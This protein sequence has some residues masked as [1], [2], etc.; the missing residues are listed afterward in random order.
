MGQFVEGRKNEEK[1][2]E[3]EKRPHGIELE[4][5]EEKKQVREGIVVLEECTKEEMIENHKTVLQ[6]QHLQDRLKNR[7]E[8]KVGTAQALNQMDRPKSIVLDGQPNDNS[9]L[10]LP[11]NQEQQVSRTSDQGGVQTAMNVI[12][13][14]EKDREERLSRNRKP[15]NRP[16]ARIEMP[17]L[18]NTSRLTLTISQLIESRLSEGFEAIK[19]QEFVGRDPDK[20]KGHLEKPKRLQLQLA[21]R[22]VNLLEERNSGLRFGSTRLRF[23]E[24]LLSTPKAWQRKKARIGFHLSLCDQMNQSS[25]YEEG[26]KKYPVY[27]HNLEI[28]GMN[29]TNVTNLRGLKQTANL[30]LLKQIS[31]PSE[32]FRAVRNR[33]S[34]TTTNAA[35][36]DGAKVQGS[37]LVVA[38]DQEALIGRE[39]SA[40]GL[41]IGKRTA[42]HF[43]MLSQSL[44]QSLKQRWESPIAPLLA[45]DPGPERAK[46]TKLTGTSK[47]KETV[48][49]DTAA[50]V[51]HA[52]MRLQSPLFQKAQRREMDSSK[53]K[54][55][56][57]SKSLNPR[58]PGA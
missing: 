48:K 50:L 28:D 18:K 44:K 4:T 1:T 35:A 12:P 47:R 56:R 38:R 53:K 40:S 16:P 54:Q 45:P 55:G 7:L 19:N 31:S 9:L 10:H 36:Q 6:Y 46:Q 15:P 11:S 5:T 52:S 49:P 25:T 29:H 43:R 2:E 17:Y 37:R 14:K 30:S 57:S 3:R 26:L 8:I 51:R 42:N 58:V 23:K 41:S 32:R 22:I 34:E 33:F 24:T 27:P 20:T 39:N 21:S 13:A